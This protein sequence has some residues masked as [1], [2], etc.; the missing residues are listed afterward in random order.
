MVTTNNQPREPRVGLLVE[1]WAEQTFAILDDVSKQLSFGPKKMY[2]GPQKD[3]FGHLGPYN[4]PPSDWMG[5]K[6]KVIQS[7]LMMWGSFDPIELGP[8]E[9]KNS[10]YMGVA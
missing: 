1:E 5:Q 4:S 9:P 2:F 6:T 7:Y 10:G 8:S 3:H